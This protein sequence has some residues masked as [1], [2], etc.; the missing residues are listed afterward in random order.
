[1]DGTVSTEFPISA[2]ELSISEVVGTRKVK[3]NEKI[4]RF[5]L[6]FRRFPDDF[7]AILV[8]RATFLAVNDG[9]RAEKYFLWIDS[10]MPG[11]RP[12]FE[13]ATTLSNYSD[14]GINPQEEWQ[15][16]PKIFLGSGQ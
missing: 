6:V 8:K 5:C 9:K 10:M 11:N 2:L 14:L 16:I 3:K 1:M 12:S 13:Q 7:Q 4:Q 15:V